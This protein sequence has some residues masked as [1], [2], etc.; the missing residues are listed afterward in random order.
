MFG[1]NITDYDRKI[2]K[3]ELDSFL[4]KNVI[5]S[6]VHVYRTEDCYPIKPGTEVYWPSRVA[7]DNSIEDLV[8][9]YKDLFPNKKVV[10]V[11]FGMPSCK[12][13]SVNNYIS[14]F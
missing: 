6:H 13:D 2:Y 3:E 11:I 7:E 14:N 8:Q 12:L 10:P 9:T 4:P 5:D 1:F